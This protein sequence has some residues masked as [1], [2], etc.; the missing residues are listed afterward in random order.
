MGKSIKIYDN[1]FNYKEEDFEEIDYWEGVL[2]QSSTVKLPKNFKRIVKETV[3]TSYQLPLDFSIPES[4]RIAYSIFNEVVLELFKT[5]IS[6]P[7]TKR[8]Y[9]IKVHKQPKKI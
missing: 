8:V 6:E 4:N 1:P 7:I 5:R 3:E 9:K 2:N